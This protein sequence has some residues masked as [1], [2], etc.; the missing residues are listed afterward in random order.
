MCFLLQTNVTSCRVAKFKTA[1]IVL[2]E[3]WHKVSKSRL[4]RK[5]SGERESVECRKTSATEDQ[6]LCWEC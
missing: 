4:N 1:E 6:A 2:E 3:T 5:V